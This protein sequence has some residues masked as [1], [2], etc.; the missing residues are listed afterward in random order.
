M[1]KVEDAILVVD[2]KDQKA[3]G[4]R[5]GF[6]R[7]KG[8]RKPERIF[9][10]VGKRITIRQE[11]DERHLSTLDSSIGTY[12]GVGMVV[13]SSAVCLVDFLLEK[14]RSHPT[15]SSSL[16]CGQR[17]LELGAGTGVSSIALA[18]HGANCTVTDLS[19][20]TPLL[21]ENCSLNAPYDGG[22]EV[23]VCPH[24]W[25]D[26]PAADSPLHEATF[27]IIIAADVLYSRECHDDLARS[28]KDPNP[29]L[30]LTLILTLTLTT[31]S[32]ATLT[33]IPN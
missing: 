24:H 18:K 6:P 23:R 17:V 30:I 2:L 29:T 3:R 31:L 25:G 12:A 8:Q 10:F 32:S 4:A 7:S 14:R 19:H 1:D 5:V 16:F 20:I 9:D 28:I 15:C 26:L 33:P 13:W 22:G 11:T 21:Q 27:D